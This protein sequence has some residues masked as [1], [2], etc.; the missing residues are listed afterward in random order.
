[1][2]P[3]SSYLTDVT[4]NVVELPD[5]ESGSF[6]VLIDGKIIKL[7]TSPGTFPLWSATIAGASAQ[8]GYKY[9]KLSDQGTV[10]QQE[11]FLRSIQ[12]GGAKSTVN[13]FFLCQVTQTSL[14]QIPQVF[15]DVQ[16]KPSKAFDHSQIAT[17]HLM[18]DPQK[19]SDMVDHPLEDI[20]VRAG[21]R[22]I[23][24]DTVYNSVKKVKVKVSGRDTRHFKKLSLRI[25]FKKGDTFFD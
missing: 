23:S 10:V 7:S 22:F 14:P 8:S 2:A 17:I 21:F 9:V 16:P 13:E 12:N 25:K 11:P 19:F 1:M 4:Y 15:E 3:A 24:A 6:G 20:E 5:T 18:P